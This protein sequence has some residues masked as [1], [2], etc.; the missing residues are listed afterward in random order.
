[1]DARPPKHGRAHGVRCVPI[2]LE[3][4]GGP[5]R[6]TDM[7]KREDVLP[8]LARAAHNAHG[9]GTTEWDD[10]RGIEREI[11]LQTAAA[12]LNELRVI[13]RGLKG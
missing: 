11:W 6:R 4:G 12:V 10:L 13:M 2:V 3:A 9:D 5:A 8:R 7:I 1:M